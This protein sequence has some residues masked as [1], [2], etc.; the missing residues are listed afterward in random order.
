[1]CKNAFAAVALPLVP[2]GE[3]KGLFQTVAGCG[4]DE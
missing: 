3:L 2:L 1:M 4:G